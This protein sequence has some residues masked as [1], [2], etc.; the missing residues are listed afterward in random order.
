MCNVK[1]LEYFPGLLPHVGMRPSLYIREE[2]PD[3][4]REIFPALNS[5]G[6]RRAEP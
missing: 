5:K 6:D 4:I 3:S 1:G 2:E